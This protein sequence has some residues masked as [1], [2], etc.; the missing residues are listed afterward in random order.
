[1]PGERCELTRQNR[2]VEH[3]QD[4]GETALV[5]EAVEQ[6]LQCAHIVGGCRDIR[7]HVAAVVAKDPGL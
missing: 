3:E 6:R 7:A 1:M 5:A 4:D 2:L